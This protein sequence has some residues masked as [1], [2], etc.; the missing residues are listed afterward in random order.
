MF[1]PDYTRA[2]N[3]ILDVIEEYQDQ[4]LPPHELSEKIMEFLSRDSEEQ[5]A[6]KMKTSSSTEMDVCTSKKFGV[7]VTPS[8]AY[9]DTDMFGEGEGE[10][11][12]ASDKSEEYKQDV[13]CGASM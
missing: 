1:H 3:S 10:G 7:C 12:F 2:M 6:D 13:P 5:D 9:D 4:I 8:F 11:D